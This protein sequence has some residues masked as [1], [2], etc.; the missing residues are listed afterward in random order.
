VGEPLSRCA[1]G[2]DA[3]LLST[4]AAG[5]RV[6]LRALSHLR[7]QVG[8]LR[9]EERVALLRCPR[10]ALAR[11][12]DGARHPKQPEHHHPPTL[13]SADSRH[14]D[15][16]EHARTELILLYTREGS[17]LAGRSREG[18]YVESRTA[19]AVVWLPTRSARVE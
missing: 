6:S 3:L 19:R 15:A 9:L 1:R 12:R 4:R 5:N 13:V 7:G 17:V 18:T 8:S 14:D 11:Q 10:C 16:T 2:D